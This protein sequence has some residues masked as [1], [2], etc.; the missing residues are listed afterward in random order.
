M[1]HD[2]GGPAWAQRKGY[3]T[4]LE[5]DRAA[6]QRQNRG[7]VV[8]QRDLMNYDLG[9]PFRVKDVNKEIYGS[10][11]YLRRKV[12]CLNCGAPRYTHGTCEYCGG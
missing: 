6:L 9:S 11:H 2:K 12:Q 5:C 3:R 7:C 1:H 10:E 8:D 4:L